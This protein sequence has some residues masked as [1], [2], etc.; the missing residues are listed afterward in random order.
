[1]KKS[2]V[3]TDCQKCGDDFCAPSQVAGLTEVMQCLQCGF[4]TAKELVFGSIAFKDL[5]KTL[6]DLYK[7][8]SEVDPKN[9]QVW[10]PSV[11]KKGK[12]IL[13]LNGTNHD[14]KDLTW[15]C[16]IPQENGNKE[17][18]N[19]DWDQYM[20]ALIYFGENAK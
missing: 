4:Y 5:Q 10:I 16:S 20:L 1:M 15:T 8:V 12:S 19:F 9:Q 6:P 17:E 18:S 13:F 3:F 2:K 7:H 14:V 11:V